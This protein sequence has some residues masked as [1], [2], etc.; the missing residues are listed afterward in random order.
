MGGGDRGAG[1][2][3]N[4]GREGYGRREKKGREVGAPKGREA[5]E[6]GENYATFIIFRNRKR[7]KG[8]KPRKKG[9]E[10]G[11]Q[12]TGGGRF[13]PP[14]PPP[15]PTSRRYLLSSLVFPACVTRFLIPLSLSRLLAH[16]TQATLCP[17]PFPTMLTL[18]FYL[19]LYS[20]IYVRLCAA[21]MDLN[22]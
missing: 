15:P 14:C 20:H 4:R 16:A 10:P 22:F 21:P 5:G 2:R 6:I 3:E 19:P 8:R 7:A 13:G 9:R 12:G 1:A 11:L 18:Q 17:V